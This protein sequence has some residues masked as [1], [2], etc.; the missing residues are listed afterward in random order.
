MGMDLDPRGHAHPLCPKDCIWAA[1]SAT[2]T[3]TILDAKTF[4]VCEAKS[5]VRF[6]YLT[7]YPYGTSMPPAHPELRESGNQDEKGGCLQSVRKSSSHV[8]TTMAKGKVD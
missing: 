7:H 3:W 2:P 6:S 4:M 1:A 5:C 8:A